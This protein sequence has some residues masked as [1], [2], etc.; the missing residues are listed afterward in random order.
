[1]MRRLWMVLGCA[2]AFL[3]GCVGGETPPPTSTTQPPPPTP[4][5]EPTGGGVDPL[6]AELSSL[7]RGQ[8]VFQ[9]PQDME[10]EEPSTVTARISRVEASP[11]TSGLDEG[12]GPVE[13]EPIDVSRQM[14][15]VLTA[16][17]ADFAIQPLSE[18]SQFVA[19]TGFT[20][21]RWSVRPQRSGELVLYLRATATV[22][23]EGE[24]AARDIGVFDREIEVSVSF[25]SRLA[26][27]LSD[28][29]QWGTGI[30]L[31]IF[32]LGVG[33]GWFKRRQAAGDGA[34]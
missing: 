1:M 2:A 24:S 8:V 31:T 17:A 10:L 26:R 21:W 14:K 6:E 19:E 30:A 9:V 20:T 7:D 22:S 32:G 29:W 25:G 12:G 27:F 23:A 34:K 3:A 15:M 4:T 18:E 11:I 5:D 13:E 16:D 28:N 33:R